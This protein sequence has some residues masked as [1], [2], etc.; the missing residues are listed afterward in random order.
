MCKRTTIDKLS[1]AANQV[2]HGLNKAAADLEKQ[3]TGENAGRIQAGE[4]PKKVDNESPSVLKPLVEA[5]KQV[6][7]VSTNNAPTIAGVVQGKFQ[8]LP[9]CAPV[10]PLSQREN[11]Y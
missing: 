8:L 10:L 9:P 11:P 7:T 6:T 3:L 4:E 1:N 2:E 5:F